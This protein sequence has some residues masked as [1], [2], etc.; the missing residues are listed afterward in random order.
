MVNPQ[1]PPRSP[2]WCEWRKVSGTHPENKLKSI[3]INKEPLHF[4]SQ[5]QNHHPNPTFP[6]NI[7]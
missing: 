1:A 6:P 3:K 5:V 7:V 2:S 4:A